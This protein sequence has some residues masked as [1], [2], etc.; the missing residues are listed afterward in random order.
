[1]NDQAATLSHAKD[2]LIDLAIGFGPRLVAALLILVAGVIVS[3]WVS[4]SVAKF[5]G[6]RQLEQPVQQLLARIAW[7]FCFALFALMAL[8]NLGIELLPLLAGLGVVGAGVALATQG[9]LSNMVAGLTIIFS[10]PFHVGEYISIAGVEGVVESEGYRPV[11]GTEMG[12]KSTYVLQSTLRLRRDDGEVT[13]VAVDEDTQV[14][15][16]GAAPAA[17]GA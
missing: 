3:N 4:R 1:M 7:A 8:Q 13:V 14:Q 6:H 17:A 9:V 15:T 16:A 11:G 10:K 5:L 2:T 12:G